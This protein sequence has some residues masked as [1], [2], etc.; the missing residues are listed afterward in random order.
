MGNRA[1]RE[2]EFS[3]DEEDGY[4]EEESERMQNPAEEQALADVTDW[5]G[6]QLEEHIRTME[7]IGGQL[8]LSVDMD[9]EGY[10]SGCCILEH[11]NVYAKPEEGL[12]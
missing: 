5:Q 3:Q 11:A 4:W 8:H 2:W 10:E 1:V 9:K 7:T 6:H 12:C